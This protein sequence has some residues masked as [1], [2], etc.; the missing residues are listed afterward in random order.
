M[1]GQ[2]T[3]GSRRRIGWGATF[4][5]AKGV[6][7]NQET[8]VL[9]LHRQDSGSAPVDVPVETRMRPVLDPADLPVLYRVVMDVVDMSLPIVF[10]ADRVLLEPALPDT[11]FASGETNIG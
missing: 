11:S 7:G 3:G 10:I 4:A 2:A 8:V 9:D 1:I 6:N 5:A